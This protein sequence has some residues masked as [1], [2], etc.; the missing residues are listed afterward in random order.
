MSPRV[1]ILFFCPP[2]RPRWVVLLEVLEPPSLESPRL[3]SFSIYNPLT[4][5][6]RAG[7][8]PER[9]GDSC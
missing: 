4:F 6:G 2:S 1:V 5:A 3:L 7:K 8:E 9:A